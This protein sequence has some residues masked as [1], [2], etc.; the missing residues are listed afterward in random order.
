MTMSSVSEREISS[1]QAAKVNYFGWSAA[2]KDLPFSHD[3]T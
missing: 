3:K 2:K 1:F